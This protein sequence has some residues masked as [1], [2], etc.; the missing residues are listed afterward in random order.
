MVGLGYVVL[1]VLGERLAWKPTMMYDMGARE[2]EGGGR[3]DIDV[4]K[5][6]GGGGG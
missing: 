4:K 1:N 3:R 5:T 2:G 6:D